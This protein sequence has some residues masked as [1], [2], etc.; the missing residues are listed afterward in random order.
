MVCSISVGGVLG[1]L[2]VRRI[3]DWKDILLEV[4]V[5][6]G[7]NFCMGFGLL[8]RP[9][10]TR[11]STSCPPRTT[12]WRG[13]T[14][15]S[16]PPSRWRA[17]CSVCLVCLSSSSL[18]VPLAVL[19]FFAFEGHRRRAAANRRLGHPPPTTQRTERHPQGSN[20]FRETL[21]PLKRRSGILEETTASIY[22]R[23]LKPESGRELD[24]WRRASCL[25]G[26]WQ[27]KRASGSCE[28]LRQ[29][30]RSSIDIYG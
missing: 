12:S 4:A 28:H 5:S 7:R 6:I 2:A 14:K 10:T 20:R 22:V 16:L 13:R 30:H 8:K 21:M 9:A 3:L 26:I 18:S 1:A 24:L 19:T 17:V 29:W 27:I 23:H 25:S 15:A 11:L